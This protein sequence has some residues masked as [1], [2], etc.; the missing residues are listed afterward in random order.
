MRNQ[1]QKAVRSAYVS[2]IMGACGSVTAF[3]MGVVT[4]ESLAHAERIKES[5]GIIFIACVLIVVISGLT[6]NANSIKK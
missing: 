4:D 5:Y 2:L 1:A 6:I 3:Y